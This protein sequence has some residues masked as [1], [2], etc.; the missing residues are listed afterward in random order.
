MKKLIF[1]LIIIVS[2]TSCQRDKEFLMEDP[3][4]RLFPDNFFNNA[5]ELELA[6]NSL[7]AIFDRAIGRPYQ[8]MSIKF[9]SSDDIIGT[10]NQRLFYNEMEVNLDIT[11]GADNDIQLGWERAYDAINQANAIINNYHNAD[12]TL[13]EA[14]LN[15]WAAQAHYI[16][17]FMYFWLVRFYNDIPLITTAFVPDTKKEVTLSKAADVYALIIADL[18]FAEEWLPVTWTGYMKKG[19]AATKGAAKST[20][21]KVYLQM[22]GYPVNGGTEY[23][24]KARDKAKE[25]IDN[26]GAYG[27]ALRDHFYQV[28]DPYWSA[29]DIP[30]DEVILWLEHTSDDYTTMAPLQSR[31]IELGGWEFLVAENAFFNRFP[32]GERKDFTFI[33]DFY[34]SGGGHYTYADLKANHPLYRKL[35]ADDLTPG[36]EW[37]KRNEPGN[38]WNSGMDKTANWYSARPNILMRYSD[39]LLTYAEAKARTDGPDVLA[40]KCLNDVRNRAY[41]GMGTDEASVSGLSNEA[42][43]DAV[44]WER[45]YEFAGSEYSSRW[46]DLQ[47]LELVEKATTEWR[48]EPESKYT[49]KKPYTRKDYFLPIPSKE[50]LFNPNLAK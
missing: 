8:S 7:Y 4:G 22:A 38:N 42:F 48:D 14:N 34:I 19:G 35:W 32:A 41:K 16:R 26:A 49:L 3:K 47:R 6:N 10:G 1:F 36:W 44:V 13:S 20:L 11:V 29:Y 2:I 18:Q 27:Y 39:I 9:A 25:V 15:A 40:Y 30:Q 5:T 43:I 23:Y 17:S 37:E 24:A 31:P 21:A 33:T 12:G 50:V 28:W 45:A 46:F